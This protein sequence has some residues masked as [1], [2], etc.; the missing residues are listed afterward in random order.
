[1]SIRLV[2]SHALAAGLA[3]GEVWVAPVGPDPSM[4][5][6]RRLEVGAELEAAFAAIIPELLDL[7]RRLGED[8]SA[9]LA[10]TP[11]AAVN[12]SDLGV[13]MAWTRLLEGWAATDSRRVVVVCDDRRLFRHWARIAGLAAG[14]EPPDPG[15]WPVLRGFAA[16]LRYGLR[17]AHAALTTKAAATPGGAWLLSYYHPGSDAQG[18]D[19]YFGPLMTERRDLRRIVHVDCPPTQAE[20]LRGDGRTLSLHGFGSAWFA[21]TRLAFARWRPRTEMLGGRWG[22]LVGRAAAIEAATAQG[23]AIAWQIHC[24]RRWLD[25]IRPQAV[26]W[27]WENHG[28]ERDLARAARSLAIATVGYQHATV[29]RYELNYHMAAN[30]DGFES[31]PDQVLCAG[32]LTRAALTRW[33][34][35]EGRSRIGGALRYPDRRGPRYDPAAPVFVAL[36]GDRALALQLV[37]AAQAL[38]RQTGR[39][40]LVRPHPI[41]DVAV[42]ETERVSRAAAGLDG[43][44][45]VSAVVYAA[46]TVGLEA[47]LYGLPTIRFIAR[48]CIAPDILP[49]TLEIAAADAAGLAEMVGQAPPPPVVV[50]AE[51]FAPVDPA[52]WRQALPPL[53]G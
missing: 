43:Q 23:A 4:P 13:M 49:N 18:G 17:A 1:M 38:A 33:G 11:S 21:L 14:S 27:P 39:R 16:R 25:R 53:Q 30:R 42:A 24:Q 7:C 40:V 8:D 46:T 29:G 26:A 28:W 50:R 52:V 22:G 2:T 31:V 41:Y 32:G 20:T 10:H 48:G 9:S 6:E 37:A 44:T 36:P 3:P 47:I 35:P 34:L 12:V 15:L 45:A 19:A 51:M 5:P